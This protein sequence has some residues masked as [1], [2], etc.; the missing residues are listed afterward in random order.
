MSPT[1]RN[2]LKINSGIFDFTKLGKQDTLY[3]S[4]ESRPSSR[5]KTKAQEKKL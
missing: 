4:I 1:T 5:Q 3:T 2:S